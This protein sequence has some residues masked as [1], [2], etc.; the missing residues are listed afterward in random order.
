[1]TPNILRFHPDDPG[2]RAFEPVSDFITRTRPNKPASERHIV[3]ELE[4][5]R[6]SSAAIT[7]NSK[8]RRLSDLEMRDPM[9]LLDGSSLCRGAGFGEHQEPMLR[10]RVELDR[11]GYQRFVGD[12]AGDQH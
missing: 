8:P 9:L 6:V 3:C 2:K 7:L 12:A 11:R 5:M 4:K 10:R 1:M